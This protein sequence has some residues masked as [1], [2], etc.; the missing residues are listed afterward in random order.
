MHPTARWQ[1]ALLCAKAA[2]ESQRAQAAVDSQRAAGNAT[3]KAG[4][5]GTYIQV[6]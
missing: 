6:N 3:L 2:G 1:A 5:G 4:G